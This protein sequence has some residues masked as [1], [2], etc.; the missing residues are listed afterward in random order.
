MAVTLLHHC[1][2]F[3]DT[4]LCKIGLIQPHW[5]W[6]SVQTPFKVVPRQFIWFE[7]GLKLGH[8]KTFEVFEV[9]VCF[10]PL[11]SSN[12]APDCYTTTT[13]HDCWRGIFTY[14]TYA[15]LQSPKIL[16]ADWLTSGKRLNRMQHVSR[17][18]G[19]SDT[20]L[21]FW[22]A[23]SLTP[24][25]M[26]VMFQTELVDSGALLKQ[27][28]WSVLKVFNRNCNSTGWLWGG[29]GKPVRSRKEIL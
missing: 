21:V 20:C 15:P 1:G 11:S 7:S 2:G 8:S 6:F 13:M 28:K 26:T 3:L 14:I 24:N 23:V 4:F 22:S 27:T 25:V 16:N 12:A 29:S 9:L 18:S 17:D 10:Q 5:F 19:C